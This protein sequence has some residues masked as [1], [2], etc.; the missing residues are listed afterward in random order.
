MTGRKSRFKRQIQQ[1]YTLLSGFLKRLDRLDEI[2]FTYWLESLP[3]KLVI[4][5]GREKIH[6]TQE[7]IEDNH[8]QRMSILQKIEETS[9]ELTELFTLQSK[10][11]PLD[12]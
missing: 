11:I 1:K 12:H 5:W 8:I 6:P 2:Q 3:D 9:I 4:Q 10:E 7:K